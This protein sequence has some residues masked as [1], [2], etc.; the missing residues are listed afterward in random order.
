MEE[1]LMFSDESYSATLM[2]LGGIST[3]LN[4]TVIALIF[5]K[6][7]KEIRDYRFYLLNFT[8]FDLL[9]NVILCCT[10]QPIPILPGGGAV[11]IGFTKAFGGIAGHYQVVEL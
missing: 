10:W 5:S 11:F 1:K 3:L 2:V 9:F 8:L 4:G 6:A 7:A